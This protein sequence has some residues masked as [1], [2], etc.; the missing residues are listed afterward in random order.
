MAKR[1]TDHELK[2]KMPAQKE[3][4]IQRVIKSWLQ[5]Q[6]WFVFKIHQSAISY[7]GIADL[8]AV[9]RGRTVWI[10]V[11]ALRGKQS[12]DQEKFQKDIEEHGGEYVLA[13]SIDDVAEY[14]GRSA[15]AAAAVGAGN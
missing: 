9:K 5:W 4:D 13:K 2:L 15:H 3:S 1:G 7:K 12:P 11:K 8:C 6:G 14:L 10:E